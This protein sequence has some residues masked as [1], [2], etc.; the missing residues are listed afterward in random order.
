MDPKEP[1]SGG[2]E[3]GD[4][5]L[6]R[7]NYAAAQRVGWCTLRFALGAV[8]LSGCSVLGFV[9]KTRSPQATVIAVRLR[10]GAPTGI[11]EHHFEKQVVS[12]SEVSTHIDLVRLEDN[13]DAVPTRAP[14]RNLVFSFDPVAADVDLKD[15]RM[16][17]G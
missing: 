2:Y 4:G 16:F 12:F 3:T 11:V 14:W 5:S 8:D 13:V 9:C 15:V 17:I 1:I 7:L 6:I 10:S